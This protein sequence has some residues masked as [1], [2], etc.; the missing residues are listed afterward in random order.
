M[1]EKIEKILKQ[2]LQ[3]LDYDMGEVIVDYAKNEK[4]G[5][6]TTN[7]AMV[8]AKEFKKN[9][10]E[11]AKEISK[12]IKDEKNT[13][14]KIEVAKPGYINFYLS[15]KYF[16]NKVQEINK[17]KENFGNSQIGKGQ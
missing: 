10:L 8:L 15:K 12:K 1:K 16:Q 5:D 13:F 2:T 17:A 7:V 11:V 3:D 9:P 6:Y 14:E 4:F